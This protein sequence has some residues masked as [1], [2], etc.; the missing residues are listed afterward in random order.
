M[1]FWILPSM[2]IHRVREEQL[3]VEAWLKL[4]EARFRE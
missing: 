2:N 4:K 3:E 1:N